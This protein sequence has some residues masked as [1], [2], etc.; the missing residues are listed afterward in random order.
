MTEL[1]IVNPVAQAKA[2]TVGAQRFPPARRPQTLDGVTI[3]LYWNAKAGGDA[4][5]AQTRLRLG[6]LYPKARF[7]DYFGEHGT[8]MRRASAEQLDRIAAECQA[9]VGTTAD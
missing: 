4:A 9:V 1:R 7:R 5:L 2:G 3:G 6:Q 8:H